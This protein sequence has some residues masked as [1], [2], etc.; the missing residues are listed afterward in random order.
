M[1]HKP[2]TDDSLGAELSQLLTDFL[3]EGDGHLHRVVG[4]VL[5]KKEEN[6]E[7][8]D[9]VCLQ[10]TTNIRVMVPDSSELPM[11]GRFNDSPL[12]G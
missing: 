8:D 10:R 4:G 7:R 11:C 3:Q 6:L 9:L 1:Q 12:A 5:Q 2:L